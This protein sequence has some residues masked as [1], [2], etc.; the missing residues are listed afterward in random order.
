MSRLI[1]LLNLFSIDLD[2]KATLKERRKEICILYISLCITMSSQYQ[3][4][5]WDNL[6]RITLSNLYRVFIEI[7]LQNWR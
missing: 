4:S 5:E 6:V 3:I 2:I 1:S 7:S